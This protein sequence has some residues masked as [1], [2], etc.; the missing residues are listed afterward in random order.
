VIETILTDPVIGQ[1]IDGMMLL[2]VGLVAGI[3]Q[4]LIRVK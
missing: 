4:R 2:A 3:F 1:L